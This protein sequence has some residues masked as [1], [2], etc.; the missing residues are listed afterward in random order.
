MW[1]ITPH[2]KTKSSHMQNRLALPCLGVVN[3]KK[4]FVLYCKLLP[5]T[6]PAT[7][8]SAR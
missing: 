6:Y 4:G 5:V 7:V 3:M 2:P 1:H 8:R